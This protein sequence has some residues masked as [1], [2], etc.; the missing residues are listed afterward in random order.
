MN[1]NTAT[2]QQILEINGR[3][4]KI[5]GSI[6]SLKRTAFSSEKYSKAEKILTD[7]ETKFNELATSFEDEKELLEISET[8]KRK[9]ENLSLDLNNA[10][11]TLFKNDFSK[12]R[13]QFSNIICTMESLTLRI[14]ETANHSYKLNGFT[15]MYRNVLNKISEIHG[16][17]VQKENNIVRIEVPCT[18]SHYNEKNL[19]KTVLVEPI[20]NAIR[21][22]KKNPDNKTK[23][24]SV[25]IVFVNHT[26]YKNTHFIRD[27]DNYDYKQIINCLAYWFISDDNYKCC[28]MLS[29]TKV[30]DKDYSEIFI[31]PKKEFAAFFAKNSDKI[32]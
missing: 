4:E 6:A 27:N 28:N 5:V 17:K 2:I 19:S 16:I 21:E 10:K 31:V 1:K 30:G 18:L 7:L 11:N 22:W 23:F 29:T 26:A 25:V 13:E 20:N 12:F 8:T 3:I 14:R 24:D 32:L 9:V 15:P